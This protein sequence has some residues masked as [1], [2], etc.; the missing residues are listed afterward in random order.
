MSELTSKQKAFIEAL[1][2]NQWNGTKAAIAA[3]YSKKSAGVMANRLLNN[4]K[5]AKDL[6]KRMADIAEKTD[7]D[8]AE[9]VAALRQI[10]F[11]GKKAT[12]TEA[13]RALELLGKYKGMFVER[14]RTEETID[15]I[16]EE[17]MKEAR[18]A[19]REFV[20][21]KRFKLIKSGENDRENVSDFS[22]GDGVGRL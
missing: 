13:L 20:E 2:V 18:Q 22:Q 17:R 6:E 15:P 5:I 4:P 14:V 10:A 3:G 19:A 1:P 21:W 16:S 11:G 12:N 7:V 8:I 9:I